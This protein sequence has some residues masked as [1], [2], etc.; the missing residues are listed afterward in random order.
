MESGG[1]ARV[2]AMPLAAGLTGQAVT[3]VIA[4]TPPILAVSIAPAFSIR[5]TDIGLFTTTLFL[6]ACFSAAVGGALVARLG[7]IRVSQLSLAAC[8]IGIGLAAS[9]VLALGVLG[10]LLVGIGYGPMTP[11]SSHLLA[12]ITTPRN[13]PFVFSLKQTSIPLGGALA[14]VLAPLLDAELG[15]R[16]A[17]LAVGALGAAAALGLEPLRSRYDAG[18]DRAAPMRPQ[19]LG[20]LREALVRPR[21]RELSLVSMLF[22]MVQI[23]LAVYFVTFLVEHAGLG[24]IEAG[25]A[26]TV[27]Q[28]AGVGGRVF[29]GMLAERLAP[30]RRLMAGLGVLMALCA[31]TAAAA[32]PDWPFAAFVALA[33][34]F[35]GTAVG[36][37]G[38][39]L[40]DIVRVTSAEESA[41]ATGAV[42]F[43]TFAGMMI[44][45]AV[46]SAVV[47][48]GAGYDTA[49]ALIALAGIVGA[50]MMIRRERV[51][52]A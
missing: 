41:R 50:G 45:P 38:L 10:A 37:N 4:L 17:C 33:A 51:A 1:A 34:I 23:C 49:F 9:G 12:P 19:L 2:L 42:A 6:V 27:A 7:P 48:L 8:A 16:G 40:A 22:A 35:G 13:R 32:D 15:W 44:A 21:L 11:A 26:L 52:V 31:L 28:S 39:L 29:W 47:A 14:G 3:A 25:V 24:L 20:P 5:P 18:R 43:F 46:F 30:T 36:W